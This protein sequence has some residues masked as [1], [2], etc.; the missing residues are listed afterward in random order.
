MSELHADGHL[1]LERCPHCQVAKPVLARQH[2]LDTQDH[3]SK[4]L[5]HWHIYA[6]THCG[7]LV[8]AACIDGRGN[9]VSEH[10]PEGR[11]VADEL[12]EK[13]RHYL[14]QA[15]S[16]THAPAGAVMLAASSVDAMLKEKGYKTGSLY[17]R[18]EQAVKDNLITSEMGEWAHDVRLDA[19]DQ[20]HSDEDASLPD[21]LAASKVIDFASA[22]GE[23]LFVLPSRVQRGRKQAE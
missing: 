23:F 14:A 22:L 2:M 5:R 13:A 1:P 10:F 11:S 16:S 8:V 12:P 9:Q 3:A 21:Q 19:N 17:S 6:C 15:V 7:G 18:I 20:R 4:I